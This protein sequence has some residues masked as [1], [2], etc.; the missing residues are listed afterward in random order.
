[1]QNVLYS[2]LLEGKKQLSTYL[3]FNKANIL[4]VKVGAAS[5]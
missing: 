2:R 3:T 5:P 1:M 4:Q